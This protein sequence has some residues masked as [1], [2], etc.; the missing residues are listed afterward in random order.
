MSKSTRTKLKDA[1]DKLWSLAIRKM[2]GNRCI[3]CYR[4][5]TLSAHH[6]I[7]RKAQTDGVRWLKYNG[8]PL[9]YVCHIQKYHGQQ[10]DKDWHEIF[11]RRVNELIPMEEQE[12]VKEIG[13]RINKFSLDDLR[14][15]IK[16]GWWNNA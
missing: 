14:D 1:I 16:N 5:T 9:C 4:T 12:K 11:I 13:H 6:V 2:Y 10:A 7:V 15:L 8:I 3:I